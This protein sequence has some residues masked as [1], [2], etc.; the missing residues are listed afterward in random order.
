MFVSVYPSFLLSS[1]QSLYPC[2]LN[3]CPAQCPSS[4]LPQVPAQAA[5]PPAPYLGPSAAASKVLAGGRRAEISSQGVSK[6][7][8]KHIRSMPICPKM[9]G[10]LRPNFVTFHKPSQTISERQRN[11]F[12]SVSCAARD[13]R[14]R[15]VSVIC[16]VHNCSFANKCCCLLI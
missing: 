11:H 5:L 8:P 16:K 1:H 15:R 4:A 10:Y 6:P 14:G 7:F 9:F 13:Y 3:S 2:Q 12:P